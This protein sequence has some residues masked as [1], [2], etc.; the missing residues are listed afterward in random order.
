MDD[1]ATY[2]STN[3]EWSEARPGAF[4]VRGI[5]NGVTNVL[6]DSSGPVTARDIIAIYCTGLGEVTNEPPNGMPA[7]FSPL[8][9]TL[10]TPQVT[11]GNVP[12]KVLF[13]GLTPGTIGLYQINAQVPDGVPTGNMVPVII[14]MPNSV[15]N[16]VTIAV[17]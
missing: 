17:H 15:S 4:G 7:P 16:T 6:A 11:I 2:R 12:S 9:T 14:A 5:V 8:A 13:S 3:V 1:R 10:V